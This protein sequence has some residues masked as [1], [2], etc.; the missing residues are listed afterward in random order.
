MTLLGCICCAGAVS[1][2]ADVCPHCGQPSPT[3]RTT[4]RQVASN[5]K[6][7]GQIVMA[8]KKVRDVTGWDLAKA[9][10]YVDFI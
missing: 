5:L 2:E 1:S 8:I 4:M 9:K 10:Q 3:S 7:Q 6:G